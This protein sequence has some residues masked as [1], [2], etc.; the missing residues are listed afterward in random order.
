LPSLSEEEVITMSKSSNT[1]AKRNQSLVLPLTIGC[2]VFALIFV[3]VGIY[4]GI[5]KAVQSGIIYEAISESSQTTTPS[6]DNFQIKI[7]SIGSRPMES[8]NVWTKYSWR[9]KLINPS[10]KGQ[11]IQAEIKW[12][13]VDGY[14]VE[15][16]SEYDLYLGPGATE[17]FTGYQL[18][19]ASMADR[20]DSVIARINYR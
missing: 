11:T 15:T 16:D 4:G 3:L 13:D 14:P 20:V 8:N 1:V 10:N 7:L 18:I 9:L 12:L 17:I 5:I 2:S 6:I 19:T